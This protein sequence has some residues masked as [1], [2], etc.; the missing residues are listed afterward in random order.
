MQPLFTIGHSQHSLE[1]FIALLQQHNVTA[2][3][4][5]RSMPYSR[6]L[7]QFNRQVLEKHLPQA[8]IRYVFLG[9]ELGARPE[10]PSCYVDGKALYEH[11][12]ATPEFSQGIK[13]ILKGVQSHRIALMCAEKDPITCHRA[14]L[15]CQHLVPFN[16]EIGHIL[17]DGSLEYHEDLE[18]RMLKLHHLQEEKL[19]DQL[20][21]FADDPTPKLT[22]EERLK[23]AYHRQG[24]KIAYVEKEQSEN[25]DD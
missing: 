6:R 24:L 17:H 23:T 22:R 16:L 7:P 21:L 20:S 13:R 11:I 2:L 18:E 19:G 3:A 9:K 10:N 4:D 15:V 1:H 5:V 25:H 8:E 12:A 14:I